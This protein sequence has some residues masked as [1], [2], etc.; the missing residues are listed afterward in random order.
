MGERRFDLKA[1]CGGGGHGDMF[2][3]YSLF[4]QAPAS[5]VCTALSAHCQQLHEKPRLILLFG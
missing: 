1:N 5:P 4:L 2:A 3:L